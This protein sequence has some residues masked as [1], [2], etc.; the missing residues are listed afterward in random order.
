LKNDI[1][2]NHSPPKQAQPKKKIEDDTA[3]NFSM[4]VRDNALDNFQ[5][6]KD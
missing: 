5:S 1:V 2:I 6:Q 3:S 4:L